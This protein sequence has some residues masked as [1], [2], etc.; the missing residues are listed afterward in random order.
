MLT[1]QKKRIESDS[2]NLT[3]DQMELVKKVLLHAYESFR[4]KGEPFPK[5]N[6]VWELVQYQSLRI[7]NEEFLDL[8]RVLKLIY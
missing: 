5:E 8:D 6:R 7:T 4:V 2:I 1:E 3:V